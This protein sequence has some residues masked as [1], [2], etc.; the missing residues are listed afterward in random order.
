MAHPPNLSPPLQLMPILHASHP[1][2]GLREASW[3]GR[4]CGF[5]VPGRCGPVR[6]EGADF[7]QAEQAGLRPRRASKRSRPPDTRA[8][9]RAARRRRCSTPSTSTDIGTQPSTANAAR[10]RASLGCKAPQPRRP[11]L[12]G[13]FSTSF[14]VKRAVSPDRRR[15]TPIRSSL[16]ARV[17][18]R[19]ARVAGEL[20]DN[21]WSQSTFRSPAAVLPR[22]V[23]SSN[24]T[25]CPSVSVIIPASFTAVMCTNTSLPPSA[26]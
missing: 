18:Q 6:R 26:G 10:L 9:S 23:F 12:G 21:R 20:H 25:F 22:S 5:R 17:R 13:A 14:Q 24:E 7:A 16:S 4:D 8:R 3:A 15:E 1:T 2:G 11:G 19:P